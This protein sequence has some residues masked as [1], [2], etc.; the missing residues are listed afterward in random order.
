MEYAAYPVI[1]PH[2][3]SF[4]MHF[5]SERLTKT[6]VRHTL[7][8]G[9]GGSGRPLNLK[10]DVYLNVS[11]PNAGYW[12]S[13]AFVDT[14]GGGDAS[15]QSI[16][17]DLLKANCSFFLTASVNLWQMN[18]TLAVQTNRTVRS[19]SHDI[20]K[21]YKYM[22]LSHASP[23][24][25]F[26]IRPDRTTTTDNSNSNSNSNSNCSIVALMRQSAFPD[27]I[28]FANNAA[29]K[30][31]TSTSN[32]SSSAR[33]S[34]TLS[35]LYPLKDTWYYL[36]VTSDCNYTL[37][38]Y[39]S[40]PSVTT[41]SG[42][43]S[44]SNNSSSSSNNCSGIVASPASIPAPI[45]TFRFI[46]PTYFAVKYYFNSNYNRSNAL[47]VRA[48]QTPYFIEFLVDLANSGG[49]LH[50]YM[51]TNLIYDLFAAESA[52]SSSTT[53]TSNPQLNYTT[54]GASNNNNNNYTYNNAGNLS[55]DEQ[56]E[57]AMRSSSNNMNNM[58][59]WTN[60]NNN[61]GTRLNAAVDEVKV[62]LRACLLYNSM[63]TYRECP[64]GYEVATQSHGSLFTNMQLNVAYPQIGKWYL[65]IWKECTNSKKYVYSILNCHFGTFFQFSFFICCS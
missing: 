34:C 13:A 23:P 54:T 7:G 57:A 3:R 37:D 59:A 60:N 61:N 6:F 44:S 36:A 28:T 38:V 16:K 41:L 2:N 8:G 30:R 14:S 58:N 45:E 32:G 50:F 33:D 15:G 31:C 18:D 55:Y 1:S 5:S 39:A 35:A 26:D 27:M 53:S 52:Q 17:P 56:F 40:A 62:M 22:S 46:G 20:F 48:D 24:F 12:F 64:P 4:P 43:C 63:A 9:S 29:F 25:V 19:T 49:T 65:A 11:S 10:Q 21:I 42:V 47:L 51:I